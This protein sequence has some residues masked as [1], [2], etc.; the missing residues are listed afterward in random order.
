MPLLQLDRGWSPDSLR[1]CSCRCSRLSLTE[2]GPLQMAVSGH[3]DNGTGNAHGNGTGPQLPFKTGKE[4]VKVR[5]RLLDLPLDPCISLAA[6]Q[7]RE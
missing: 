7:Q 6:K 1:F 5:C 3:S 2:C 4:S